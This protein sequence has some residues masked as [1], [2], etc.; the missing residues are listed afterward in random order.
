MFFHLEVAKGGPLR[1]ERL[2]SGHSSPGFWVGT[3]LY[4]FICEKGIS[5]QAVGNKFKS[6]YPQRLERIQ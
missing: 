1:P 2:G 5:S 4:L 3:T 6:I